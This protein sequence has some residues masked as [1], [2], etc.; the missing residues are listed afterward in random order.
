MAKPNLLITMRPA[1]D[2]DLGRFLMAHYEVPYKERPHAP[3][4]H[5]FALKWWG[6][7]DRGYPLFVRQID[8]AQFSRNG[9]IWGE[10]DPPEGDPKNLWP[11][12]MNSPKEFSEVHE[13][14]YYIRRV[15]GKS[16]VAWSYFNLL[17]H[18]KVVW[19]S[20][21]TGVPWYEKFLCYIGFPLVRKL[22][23]LGLGI[24]K[25]VA[26]I[27]ITHIYEGFDRIDE[28]SSDGRQ[29]LVGDR[30]T[31]ADLA[32]ATSFGPMILAQGYE[33]CLPNQV[34]CPA[35]MQKIYKEL[36][37]RPTGQLIQ[38]IYDEHRPAKQVKG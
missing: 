32:L 34:A 19:S 25:E 14:Q 28:L 12:P 1:K 18:K 6:Y 33:G 7:G 9:P 37:Q 10:L 17:Q 29:Y 35:Y 31:F 16:V 20:I 2:V 3:I 8:K 38:R 24:D 11:D 30:L 27:A 4:F 22:M 36:R 23:Y 13:L 15:V 5:V 21:T 26:D